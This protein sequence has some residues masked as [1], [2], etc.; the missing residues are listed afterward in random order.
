MDRKDTNPKDLVGQTKAQLWLIPPAATI[1]L[2]EA[3]TDGARKYQPYNW[4]EKGVRTSIYLS[5]AQRHIL[6]FLDGEDVAADSG[7]SHLGH[8]MA[9]FAIV[10]DSMAQGNIVDDRPTKGKAS[11]LLEAVHKKRV[12][13]TI[14]ATTIDPSL[15]SRMPNL[16]ALRTNYFNNLDKGFDN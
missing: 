8:A 5:A 16:N 1:A 13:K 4:R 3:L 15:F 10:L 7:V 14:P 6:A 11:E 9:C 2:A 12:A